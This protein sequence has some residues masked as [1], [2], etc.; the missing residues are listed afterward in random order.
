MECREV[1][2][3]KEYSEDEVYIDAYA[4]LINK[5]EASEVLELFCEDIPLQNYGLNHLKRVQPL[6]RE[7]KTSPVQ[8]IVC[9][10]QRFEE[11]PENI[12]KLCGEKRVVRVSRLAPACREEFEAWNKCWP[13]NFHASHLEKQ[14]EKG[15][16][17]Q[18]LE[19]MQMAVELLS[20]E[21]LYF[22]TSGGG[23]IVNPDNGRVVTTTSEAMRAVQLRMEMN[24]K[25]FDDPVFSSMYT[26][27]M[28]CIDGVAA[29]VR[30]ELTNRGNYAI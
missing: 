7:N 25:S 8:I 13:I 17:A 14:R 11:A 19:Q 12:R 3:K 30:G 5:K 9:P 27:T 24:N 21:E 2:V 18:D 15:L 1:I 22:S 23:V 16:T 26:A 10:V 28:I 4:A 29:V 20:Q 6:D